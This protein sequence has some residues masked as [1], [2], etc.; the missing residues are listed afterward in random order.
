MKY[1]VRLWLSLLLLS[2]CRT[3]AA[4]APSLLSAGADPGPIRPASDLPHEF[5]WRQRVTAQWNEG[6]QTFEA[7]L[8]KRDG[9]L[10]LVGLSPMGLPG[11]VLKLASDGN[12]S[13]ENRTQRELPFP[14]SFI[15]ADVQKAYFDWLGPV[16]PTFTGERGGERRG[17]RVSE[18]FAQGKLVERSFRR[19]DSDLALTVRYTGFRDGQLSP[20]RVR[21]DNAWFGYQLE[22]ETLEQELL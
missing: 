12:I 14:P 16:A 4:P 9:E 20:E 7:V 15:L 21:L 22:I 18:T 13:F 19:P 1:L 5:Q 6:K 10:I 3:T 17:L 8:Q 2:A 11:F